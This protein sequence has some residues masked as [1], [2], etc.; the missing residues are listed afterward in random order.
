MKELRLRIRL[1]QQ[2]VADAVHVSRSTVAKWESGERQP[3]IK[4]LVPLAHLYLVS[5]E[6]LVEVITGK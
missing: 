5:L 1:T 2:N 3:E 4:L 6:R